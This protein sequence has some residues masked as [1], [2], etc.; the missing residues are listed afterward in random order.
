MEPG[1]SAVVTG[2][3]RGIGRAVAVALTRRGFDVVATMRNPDQGRDLPDRNGANC[4]HVERLD[5]TD[6]SGFAM[7]ADLRVL[8]NNAGIE[9]ILPVE[10][11]SLDEWRRM[12]GTTCS[13]CWR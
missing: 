12:F 11:A 1:G 10:H 2:A 8:V 7:P 6:P 3:S 13:G 5:V 4:N 9:E